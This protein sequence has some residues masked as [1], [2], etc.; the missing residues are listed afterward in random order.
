MAARA[1]APLYLVQCRVS[2]DVAVRRWAER[3]PDNIRLDLSA[4]RVYSDAATYPY[5][6]CGLVLD[7][8]AEPLEQSVARVIA[9]LKSGVPLKP[10]E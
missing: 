3:G 8:A 5:C 9:Y 2:P 10:G 1:A 4:E 6:G 7:T